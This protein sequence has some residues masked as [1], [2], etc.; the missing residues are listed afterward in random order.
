M[1]LSFPRNFR[2]FFNKLQKEHTVIL[3][4]VMPRSLYLSIELLAVLVCDSAD[5]CLHTAQCLLYYIV[6]HKNHPCN[7]FCNSVKS[8]PVFKTLSLTDCKETPYLSI[9]NNFHFI[10]NALLHYLVK[11]IY[12]KLPPNFHYG[13][14]VN[15]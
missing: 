1:D 14:T 15:L 8:Q 11:F 3:A 9:T 7:L 10:L 6:I 5:C 12:S 13:I 4:M 2:I